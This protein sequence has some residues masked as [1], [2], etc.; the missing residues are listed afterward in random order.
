MWQTPALA[1]TRLA[2]A[3]ATTASL[4]QAAANAALRKQSQYEP[5]VQQPRLLLLLSAG[6]YYQMRHGYRPCEWDDLIQMALWP[7]S[8]ARLTLMAVHICICL[9]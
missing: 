7:D 6:E 4:V 8:A 9:I 5:T 3:A 2:Q 1:L